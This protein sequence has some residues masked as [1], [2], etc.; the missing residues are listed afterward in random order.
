MSLLFYPLQQVVSQEK[1]ERQPAEDEKRKRH[2]LPFL[3]LVQSRKECLFEINDWTC[4]NEG[5]LLVNPVQSSLDHQ[6]NIRKG[7]MLAD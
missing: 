5:K 4:K 7:R 2:E 1:K 6:P 3:L